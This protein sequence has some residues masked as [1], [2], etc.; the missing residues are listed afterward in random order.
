[1]RTPFT[2]TDNEKE[3]Y[4][5]LLAIALQ[6]KKENHAPKVVAK[7]RGSV[8][9]KL[10]EI[11]KKHKIDIVKDPQLISILSALEADDY[12]PYEA[13]GA[14]AT[15]LSHIYRKNAALRKAH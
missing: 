11:A 6:Y 9:E 2:M 8:A 12:I 15:I 14:V 7:G 4:K 5:R 13:Y 3:H 10:I 1:M